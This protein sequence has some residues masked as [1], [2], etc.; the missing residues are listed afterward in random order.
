MTS[1]SNKVFKINDEIEARMI[2][3]NQDDQGWWTLIIYIITLYSSVTYLMP[4]TRF[5][6]TFKLPCKRS[7]LASELN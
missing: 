3:Q 7:E 4:K 6:S 5:N 1:F 2:H